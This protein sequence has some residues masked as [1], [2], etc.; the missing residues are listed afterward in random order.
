MESVRVFEAGVDLSQ[1][2]K[3]DKTQDNFFIVQRHWCQYVIVKTKLEGAVFNLARRKF[4]LGIL[5]LRAHSLPPKSVFRIC[6]R[7]IFVLLKL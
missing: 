4:I 5:L 6:R 1:G 7:G 2:R 3:D